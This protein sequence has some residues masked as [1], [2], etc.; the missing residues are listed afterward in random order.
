MD[1]CR[2]GVISPIDNKR[3]R[4]NIKTKSEDLVVRSKGT[5]NPAHSKALNV[6]G[7]FSY[8][9]GRGGPHQRPCPE[10]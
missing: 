2:R 7:K 4:L 3:D 9:A 5:P 10:R 1:D 8:K 6:V